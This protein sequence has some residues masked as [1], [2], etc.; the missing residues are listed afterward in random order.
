MAEKKSE[1]PETQEKKPRM[2][3]EQRFLAE[4]FHD[5]N[6]TQAAIRAGYSE[7]S[8]RQIASRLLSK[9]NIARAIKE[10]ISERVMSA[11]ETLY[12]LA[13]IARGTIEPFITANNTI[14]LKSPEAAASLGLVRSFQEGTDK[15]GAKLELHDS[16]KALE[17]LGKANG[18]LSNLKD[19]I[20]E[21]LDVSKLTA[22]QIRALAAGED[23]LNVLLNP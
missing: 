18:A 21:N 14:N 8:A 2:S 5:F 1:Q 13:A 12:R 10:K 15:A 4:Y 19:K 17:L 11:D 16:L 22:N 6:G 9:A 20:L 7:R 3:K 23:I